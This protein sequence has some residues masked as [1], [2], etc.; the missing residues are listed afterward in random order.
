MLCGGDFNLTYEAV[1]Q[2]RQDGQ[3]ERQTSL[4]ALQRRESSLAQL[5]VPPSFLPSFSVAWRNGRSARGR[6]VREEERRKSLSLFCGDT[7]VMPCHASEAER[8]GAEHDTGEM[9]RKWIEYGTKTR[10]AFKCS[11]ECF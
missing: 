7:Y 3:T 8:S 4:A 11:F 5:N 10:P 2:V 6:P 1:C 9:D